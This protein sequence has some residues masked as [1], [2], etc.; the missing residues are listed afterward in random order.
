MKLLRNTFSLYLSLLGGFILNFIQLKLLSLYLAPLKLG[1]FFTINAMGEILSHILLLGS[2]F[3]VVRYLPKFKAETDN[4]KIFSLLSILGVSYLLLSILVYVCLR[5]F[6][7]RL[8]IAMYKS[9]VIGTYLS[10]GFIVSFAIA[11]FWLIFMVFNGIRKM[12]YAALLNIFYLLISTLTIWIF[13]EKLSVLLVLKIYLFSVL[14]SIVIGGLLLYRETGG[15][16]RIDL[17]L[18]SEIRYYWKY[19]ILLGCLSPLFS[20]LDR[21]L[22][23]Y[24]LTLPMVAI[25]TIASK[26]RG[27]TARVLDIPIQALTPEMSYAWEKDK[28]KVIGEEL[29]LVVKLYF[30]VALML[31][32]PILVG[33]REI[34]CLV[35]TDKYVGAFGTLCF[36]MI[37]TLLS[38]L[39]APITTAMRAIGKIGLH[40]YANI[41]WVAGYAGFMV[42]LI[43]RFEIVGIGIAHL[44]AT[45]MTL[46]FVFIYIVRY[47]TKLS[48]G[49]DFFC[50]VIGFSFVFGLFT[51]F[52]W[53]HSA[54]GAAY[55]VGLLFLFNM[56]IYLL[57]L[58]RANILSSAEKYR[59]RTLFASKYSFLSKIL[60]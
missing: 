37:S 10:F 41:I 54:T 17:K 47:H 4:K 14:P 11:F 23:G 42:L 40:L 30:F 28:Q 21:L 35:S 25:F 5:L 19:A 39:Y 9:E 51:Y 27:W 22:V 57:F 55:K 38:A 45:G 60:N 46:L 59:L 48:I 12:H 44:L 33:G 2:P 20:Y 13:R 29:S 34:I 49:A 3:V 1:E 50:K 52:V 58:F 8:G 24:F 6:G 7:Y 32:L 18:I 15:L 43:P 36:L 56:S 31:S 53:Q 16:H 26:I